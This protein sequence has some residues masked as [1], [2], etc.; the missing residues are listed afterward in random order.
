MIR[1]PITGDPIEQLRRREGGV[2]GPGGRPRV[3]WCS[4]KVGG[5]Q[6]EKLGKLGSGRNLGWKGRFSSHGRIPADG[7]GGREGGRKG[8]GTRGDRRKGK[9]GRCQTF[10]EMGSRRLGIVKRSKGTNS[11]TK[12]ESG[13]NLVTTMREGGRG[14]K[15]LSKL[16]RRKKVSGETVGPRTIYVDGNSNVKQTRGI[17]Q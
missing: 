13:K 2:D 7:A 6:P 8:D 3:K 9:L 16:K 4:G 15:G 5:R 10:L 17:N 14:K 11:R 12:G 1:T